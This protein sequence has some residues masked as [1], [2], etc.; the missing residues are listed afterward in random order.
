VVRA[1]APVHGERTTVRHD[2][3]GLF[4][5]LRSPIEAARY[6]SLVVDPASVPVA[7]E[8]SAWGRGRVVMALRHRRRP[9][10]SVQFH[11][12][13]YLTAAGPRLFANFLAGARR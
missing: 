8:V 4:T 10:D 3:R 5:G 9:V 1:R 6:H 13:S 11:P 12:E 7:L 2:R